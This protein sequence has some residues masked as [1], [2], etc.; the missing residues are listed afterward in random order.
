MCVICKDHD[1]VLNKNYMIELYQY[2]KT[3]SISLIILKMLKY[4]AKLLNIK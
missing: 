2:G 1:D 3:S 4:L